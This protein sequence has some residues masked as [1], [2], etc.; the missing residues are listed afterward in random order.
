MLTVKRKWGRGE[1]ERG[2]G[3][4]GGGGEREG[5]REMERET[6]R[7]RERERSEARVCQSEVMFPTPPPVCS[8]LQIGWPHADSLNRFIK[9]GQAGKHVRVCV[10]LFVCVCHTFPC[11]PSFW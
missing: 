3:E 8:C 2:G 7:E 10:R 6:E 11:S 4:G 1:R 9:A 5:E